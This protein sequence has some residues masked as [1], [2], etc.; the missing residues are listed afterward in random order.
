MPGATVTIG[1]N[2]YKTLATIAFADIF[3]AGDV[4]RAVPWALKNADAKA[5]GM[6]SATRKLIP[7]PWITP[8]DPDA[9][10]PEAVMEAASMLASDLA[11]KP[12]LAANSTGASNIKSAKAGSAQVEFFS[13]VEAGPPVSSE[14]WDLLVAAGLIGS[15]GI[16]DGSYEGAFV[17]GG[18][19]CRPYEGRYV[20]WCGWGYRDFE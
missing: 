9:D 8:L 13:P 10:Q 15:A 7:L 18:D 19:C 11:A 12:K 14:I 6:V 5:R 3:L 1:A 17:S 20:D 4:Q 16:S 2:T